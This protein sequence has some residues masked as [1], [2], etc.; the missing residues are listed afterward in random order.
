MEIADFLRERRIDVEKQTAIVNDE[1]VSLDKESLNRKP[2][3]DKWSIAECFQHLNLTMEYYVP[4]MLD[5]VQNKDQFPQSS[6][7]FKQSLFG[8][9]A[10]RS[11][12]P[13]PEKGIQY[14]MKTFKSLDP[15][16]SDLDIE[17]VQHFLNFQDHMLQVI[18]GLRDMSLS[19]PKIVTIIG[20]LLKM[21]IGDAL[22]FMVAHNQ[23]HIVQA[24]N[25]L[26]IIH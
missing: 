17:T 3:P 5:A 18:D 24:Q 9:L 12:M 19:K 2:S 11:M 1:F 8:K 25:V 7:S 13:Q 22:H 10:V 16:N 23:R 14:K 26:K 21:R 4:Q 6:N 20:P 15:A